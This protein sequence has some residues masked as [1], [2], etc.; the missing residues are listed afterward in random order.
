MGYSRGDANDHA[1]HGIIAALTDA[2]P[3]SEAAMNQRDMTDAVC[4]GAA[5]AV[6]CLV[7]AL[8]VIAR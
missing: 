4:L 2:A 6:A 7:I 3:P 8:L 5:L 1:A